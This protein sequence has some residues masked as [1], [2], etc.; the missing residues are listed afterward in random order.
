MSMKWIALFLVLS[1]LAVCVYVGSK[2]AF[3]NREY[4]M[5]KNSDDLGATLSTSSKTAAYFYSPSC[6]WCT[7]M[8]LVYDKVKP[9]Y[10]D[11]KFIKIDSSQNK[12]LVNQY[13]LEG[14]PHILFF[15][16]SDVVGSSSGYVDESTLKKRLDES[17]A[18]GLP[19]SQ[20]PTQKY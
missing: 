5:T 20:N 9:A 13:K 12:D 15:K 19:I 6:D 3:G 2:N 10:K 18:A 17:F 8:H 4:L 11:V 7:K 1:F 16:G 14:F